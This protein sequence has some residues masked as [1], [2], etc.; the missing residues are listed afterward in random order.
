V[1]EITS[2]FASADFQNFVGW[3][4]KKV[5]KVPFFFGL[6][7]TLLPMLVTIHMVDIVCN[8]TYS[9]YSYPS[10]ANCLCY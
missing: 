10:I 4:P 9:S 2:K 5:P 7:G 6:E 1:K 3:R 8:Q